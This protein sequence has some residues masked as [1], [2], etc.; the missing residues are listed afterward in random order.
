MQETP[1]NQWPIPPWSADWQLWQQQFLDLLN[2]Q[3]STVFANMENIKVVFSSIPNASVIDDAGTAKLVMTGDLVLISRTLNTSITVDSSTDLEL[4]AGY[5]IGVVLTPGAVGPQDTVFELYSSVE[6]DPSIQVFGYVDDAY[7]INWFNGSTL[8]QGDPARQMFSFKSTAG[9]G[10]TYKVMTTAADTTPGYLSSKLIQGS[11]VTLTVQN[12]GAN[13]NILIDASG[14]GYWDRTG[15]VLSPLNSGDSVQISI[16]NSGNASALILTQNDTV[17]DEH[18]L[19]LVQNASSGSAW[20]NNQSYSIYLRGTGGSDEGY[21][22]FADDDMIIGNSVATGSVVFTTRSKTTSA[23]NDAAVNLESLSTYTGNTLTSL[24]LISDDS[25]GGYR[26]AT[27]NAEVD[28]GTSSIDAGYLGISTSSGSGYASIWAKGYESP[29]NYVKVR[30]KTSTPYSE[31]I[32]IVSETGISIDGSYLDVNST[33]FTDSNNPVGWISDGIAL[34]ASGSEWDNI[35]TLLGGT[36]GSIFGAILA[37]SGGYWSRVGTTLSPITSGDMVQITIPDATNTSALELIQ[38]DV[39]NQVDAL[40]IEKNSIPSGPGNPWADAYSIFLTGY[41]DQTIWSDERLSVGKTGSGGGFVWLYLDETASGGKG[42]FSSRDS[43]ATH[44]ATVE[45]NSTSSTSYVEIS[46]DD[47]RLS[48]G[49]RSGST[50]SSDGI[51]LSSNSTEWD[52]I[53]ILIGSEGSLF[54]AILAAYSGIGTHGSTHITGQSDE[55]DGDKLDIDWDPSNYTPATTPT[56][57]DSVDNLTAHLYGIDQALSSSG[58][59]TLDGAYDYG[60]AGVGNTINATDGAVI[61][62]VADTSGNSALQL[63]QNDDTNNQSVLEITQNAST[64]N[65]YDNAYSISLTG[66]STQGQVIFSDQ[67]III[68][69]YKTTSSTERSV[70]IISHSHGLDS[71]ADVYIQAYSYGN[72]GRDS[73]S[74]II[75]E[76]EQYAIGTGVDAGCNVTLSATLTA[77]SPLTTSLT[78]APSVIYSTSA[79]TVTFGEFEWDDTVDTLTITNNNNETNWYDTDGASIFLNGTATQGNVIGSSGKLIV[80]VNRSDADADLQLFCRNT[81]NYDATITIKSEKTSA[82]SDAAKVEIISYTLGGEGG[83]KSVVDV[84]AQTLGASDQQHEV[85]L[86]CRVNMTETDTGFTIKEDNVSLFG[87]VD[88]DEEDTISVVANAFEYDPYNGKQQ[89]ATISANSTWS[90]VEPS[91]RS[92]HGILIVENSDSSS[93][94]LTFTGSPTVTFYGGESDGFSIPA[95]SSVAITIIYRGDSTEWLIAPVFE[96]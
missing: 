24:Q 83:S 6:I 63:V 53:E 20:D 71:D 37:S 64:T 12:P 61:I 55:I 54:G 74:F 4:Q 56:E 89:V 52:N 34:S 13:E 58:G 16:P 31:N 93:H 57:V 38:N 8:E 15:T 69:N 88:F 22:I 28:A 25:D 44:V 76:A 23:G 21:V 75:L 94:T 73:H 9:G 32:L 95:T 26:K 77:P 82:A 47:I 79:D 85:N 50:W 29:L 90:L 10:D 35:K 78:V 62:T 14:T 27:F 30:A 36:E 2:D 87:V 66:T 72:T 84:I 48:D 11:G 46:A 70:K 49:N 45:V 59:V 41:S 1:R 3:D 80:G 67:N 92:T 51:V 86:F 18:V 42:Y 43:G 5:M 40:V 39:T 68:G 33:L 91:G 7:T 96:S 17:N 19:E 65:W 81:G 60:G